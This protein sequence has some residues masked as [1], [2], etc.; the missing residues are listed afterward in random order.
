VFLL[1]NSSDCTIFIEY[2]LFYNVGQ[3]PQKKCVTLRQCYGGGNL[4]GF[5]FFACIAMGLLQLIS[6]KFSKVVN[7]SKIRW[8]RT[9]ATNVPSEET[10]ANFIRHTLHVMSD[11]CDDS[12]LVR[13]IRERQYNSKSD[14]DDIILGA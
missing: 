11:K 4:E 12:A 3:L 8:L 1:I 14:G 7:D 5:V 9:A 6:L 10:T 13:V 2:T